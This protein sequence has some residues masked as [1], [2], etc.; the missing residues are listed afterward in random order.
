MGSSMVITWS[1]RVELMRSTMAASVVD[2]PEPVV[3]VTSTR[4]RCSS[5]ILSITRGRF[6]SSDGANLGGDHA[7]HHAHV[8]ALL[9]DVDAEAPQSGHAVGHVQLGGFLEFLLLAVGHHAER[10][11]QHLFRRDARHVGLRDSARRPRANR[12]G[13]RPSDAGRRPSVR[14]RGAADRQCS[15]AIR[16]H[17]ARGASNSKLASGMGGNKRTGAAW[18]PPS[19]CGCAS[20]AQLCGGTMRG[21]KSELVNPSAC[22]RRP[23]AGPP[24]RRHG[25]S[26]AAK[27]G[28]GRRRAPDSWRRR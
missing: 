8:A 14:P 17:P 16:H 6:S 13:C 28:P 5:Q 26:S 27:P 2:L 12:G 21:A 25:W 23:P 19:N 3:P 7:Q 24:S 15:S 11:R 22:Q 9:E 18:L 1:E 10:H 4:P 20:E